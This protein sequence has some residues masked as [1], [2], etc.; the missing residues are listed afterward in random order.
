M[1]ILLENMINVSHK[2]GY[3]P[4]AIRLFGEYLF[5]IPSADNNDVSVIIQHMG[6][7]IIYK[8]LR[9]SVESTILDIKNKLNDHVL[10][11]K[12]ENY[13][14]KLKDFNKNEIFFVVRKKNDEDY[15]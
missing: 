10:L 15:F 14:I 11:L 7:G 13:N 1:T 9:M 4:K 5:D 12:E 2:F 3:N 8:Q 6:S